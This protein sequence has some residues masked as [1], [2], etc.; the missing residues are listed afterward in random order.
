MTQ[1]EETQLMGEVSAELASVR[2]RVGC[3]ETKLEQY[4]S[5]LSQASRA[6]SGDGD[7]VFPEASTWP[8]VEELEQVRAS[9]SEARTRRWKL[10]TRMKEWGVIE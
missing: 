6:L 8:T 1:G 3:L 9:L 2:R 4:R 7:E 10:T 5:L